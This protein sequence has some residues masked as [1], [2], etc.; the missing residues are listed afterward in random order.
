MEKNHRWAMPPLILT[1]THCQKTVKAALA[2]CF[3]VRSWYSSTPLAML[4]F[5]ST[6]F[7]G[8]NMRGRGLRYCANSAL[9]VVVGILMVVNSAWAAS[10]EKVLYSFTGGTD[11]G[12]PAAALIFD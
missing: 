1:S 8:G 10:K 5:R 4:A 6:Q 3:A 9:V 12:D 7:G 2:A 11:G